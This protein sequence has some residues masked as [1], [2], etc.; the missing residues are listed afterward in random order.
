MQQ[1]NADVVNA[2]L[3]A[4]GIKVNIQDSIDQKTALMY[5]VREGNID[6]VKA[7]LEA[8]GID[9]NIQNKYGKTALMYAVENG[10]LNAVIELLSRG[11]KVD[12]QNKFGT[13]ALMLAEEN[14]NTDVINLLRE[15][16]AK[17]IAAAAS[18]QS[19]ASAQVDTAT[20]R[21]A[22]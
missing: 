4:P 18:P 12:I 2:L 10:N 1:G 13:T 8:D 15:A 22:S 17:L 6:L 14:R 19:S 11:S 16:V 20:N 3:N 5:A 9:V 21:N 7:L